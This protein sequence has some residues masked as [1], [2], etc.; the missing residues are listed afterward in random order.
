MSIQPKKYGRCIVIDGSG[1]DPLRGQDPVENY[2]EDVWKLIRQQIELRSTGKLVLDQMNKYGTRVVRIKPQL[3]FMRNSNVTHSGREIEIEFEPRSYIERFAKVDGDYFGL[4]TP[5]CV[6]FHELFH[7]YRALRGY[8]YVSRSTK[9]GGGWDDLAEFN[10]ILLTNI[11]R[12]EKYKKT[13][14]KGHLKYGHKDYV[15]LSG[16]TDMSDPKDFY[17][18]YEERINKLC[19]QVR[20]ITFPLS[21]KPAGVIPWNPLRERHVALTTWIPDDI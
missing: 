2:Q 12:S 5:D 13:K 18:R 7:A 15:R 4:S 6:L 11:F 21:Q 8:L 17:L 9:V 16:F 20:E 1:A 19:A 10:A 14:T 3:L